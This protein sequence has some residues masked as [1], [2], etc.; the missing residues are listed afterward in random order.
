MTLAL[1]SRQQVATENLPDR[2]QLASKTPSGMSWKKMIYNSI[3]TFH[4]LVNFLINQLSMLF[5]IF[6]QRPDHPL[7]HDKELK[8]IV[9]E[10]RKAPA[11]QAIEEV[12]SWF[13][14]LKYAE[15]FSIDSYFNIVSQLDDAAQV[16]LRRMKR[17]YLSLAES[18]KVEE[19]RQWTRNYA[20]YREA[21]TLYES[22]LERARSEPKNKSAE[23]FKTTLPLLDDRLQAL[24]THQIKWLAYRYTTT[25]EPLWRALG[26]TFAAAEEAGYAN[27]LMPLYTSQR[28]LTSVLQQYLHAVVFHVSSLDRLTLEQIDLA[29]R[30]IVHFLPGFVFSA[31]VQPGSYW[32][33][34][35]SGM[36][37]SRPTRK[38]EGSPAGIRFLSATVAFKA[39]SS[40]TETLE[41]G[42]MPGDLDLGEQSSSGALLSV[43][44]HLRLYWAPNPPQRRHVRHQVA[45]RMSVVS[46]FFEIHKVFAHALRELRHMPGAANWSSDNVSLGGFRACCEGKTDGILKLGSLICVQP[47]GSQSQMLGAIRRISRR[48]DGHADL[49]VQVLAKQAR[50]IQLQPRRSGFSAANQ[51][52]GLWLSDSGPSGLLRIILPIGQF[53]VRETMEFHYAGQSRLLTPLEIEESGTDYEVARFRDSG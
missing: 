52:P 10:I 41:R 26:R 36:A 7:A 25:D 45:T 22:C 46:D 35:G 16:H 53:N 21:A 5:N 23:A 1:M 31:N 18:S 49:G 42:E 37:P 51:I 3:S 30:L 9:A 8:R 6:P 32:L 29:D 43:A 19:E 50:A 44:R 12:N 40:L 15:K 39:L 48:R 24:R 2:G 4:S 14:S 34:I 13:E 20:Y 11:S 28:S 27:K 17:E 47:E 33:N 38:P